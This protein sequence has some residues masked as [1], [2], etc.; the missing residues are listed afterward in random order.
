[1]RVN[2][3]ESIDFLDGVPVFTCRLFI[4]GLGWSYVF[5][6]LGVQEIFGGSDWLLKLLGQPSDFRWSSDTHHHRLRL[7]LSLF[8]GVTKYC[9]GLGLPIQKLFDFREDFWLGRLRL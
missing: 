2:C 9:E 3:R 6:A 7:E 5:F 1:V 4:A 8:F